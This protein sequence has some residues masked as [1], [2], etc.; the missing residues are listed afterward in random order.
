[1]NELYNEIISILKKHGKIYSYHILNFMIFKIKPY[2][3]IIFDCDTGS[4]HTQETNEIKQETYPKW[5]FRAKDI[6]DIDRN[7]KDF[8]ILKKELLNQ[9]QTL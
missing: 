6:P 3:L 4:L 1:M 9:I 5:Y 7:I 8:E 2:K